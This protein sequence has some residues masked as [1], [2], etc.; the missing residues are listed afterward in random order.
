MFKGYKN[1]ISDKDQT[2]KGI[3]KLAHITPTEK[4]N[5]TKLS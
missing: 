3:N 1:H 2:N 4:K 5:E